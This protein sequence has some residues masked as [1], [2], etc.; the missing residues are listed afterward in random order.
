MKTLLI[1]I[2]RDI[3]SIY[4]NTEIFNA[5]KDN[6]LDG[7]YI[8]LGMAIAEG[9]TVSEFKPLIAGFASDKPSEFESFR[10]QWEKLKPILLGDNPQ[11]KFDFQLS[12][13]YLEWLKINASTLYYQKF[14]GT[15]QASVII[16][17]E[18]LYEDTVFRIRRRVLRYLQ[19]NN[20]Y[21]KFEDFVVFTAVFLRVRATSECL[22]EQIDILKPIT[23]LSLY[24]FKT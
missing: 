12:S 16:D 19:E 10:S 11:G 1:N 7:F 18:E 14:Q 5:G 4:P 22:I 3:T 8:S 9:V 21:N 6:I 24:H 13:E 20:N 2:Y 15:R 17:I 23:D